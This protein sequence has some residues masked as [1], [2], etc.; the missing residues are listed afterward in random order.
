MKHLKKFDEHSAYSI[1]ME[2]D[3]VLPNVSY[4]SNLKH[5]H[6]TRK[7]NYKKQC[8]TFEALEDG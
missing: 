5:I 7:P 8:L 2:D 4:C 3:P 1:Y 6:N